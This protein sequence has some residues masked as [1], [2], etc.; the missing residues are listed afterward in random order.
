LRTDE[1]QTNYEITRDTKHSDREAN[2][3]RPVE[4]RRRQAAVRQTNGQEVEKE[5]VGAKRRTDSADDHHGGLMRSAEDIESKLF[6][7]A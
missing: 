6:D 4:G 5:E 1:R 3:P 7:F 2:S